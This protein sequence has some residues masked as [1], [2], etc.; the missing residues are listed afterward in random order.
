MSGE[1]K[2]IDAYMARNKWGQYLTETSAGVFTGSRIIGKRYLT[3][4][5]ADNAI[6]GYLGRWSENDRLF[7]NDRPTRADFKIVKVTVKR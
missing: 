3:M 1:K 4:G 6:A 5:G 2:V 7:L